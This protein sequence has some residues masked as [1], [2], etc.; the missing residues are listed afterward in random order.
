MNVKQFIETKKNNFCEFLRTLSNDESHLKQLESLK[1]MPTVDFILYI[2][3]Y[4]VPYKND[5]N[6]FIDKK[7]AEYLPSEKMNADN[8]NKLRDYLEMFIDLSLD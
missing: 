1:I 2:K 3:E 7:F 8:H 4:V 6:T 5:L